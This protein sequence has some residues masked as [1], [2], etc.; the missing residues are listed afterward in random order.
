MD[1]ERT[2]WIGDVSLTIMSAPGSDYFV[3]LERQPNNILVMSFFKHL[4][5]KR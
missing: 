3:K 5:R 2:K 4:R 1:F